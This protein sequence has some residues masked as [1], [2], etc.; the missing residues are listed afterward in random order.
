MQKIVVFGGTGYIGSSLCEALLKS[1]YEVISISQSGKNKYLSDTAG[2]HIC[3]IRANVLSDTHWQE[4]LN[5]CIAVVNSI[6]ILFQN[7]KSGKTYKRLI[8][9][10]SEKIAQVAVDKS[11]PKFIHISAH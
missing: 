9:D 4:N 7:K 8:T 5:G 1:G 10:V 11:V 6:G 2:K 3:F